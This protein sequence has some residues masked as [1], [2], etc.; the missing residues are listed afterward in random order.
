M[1]ERWFLGMIFFISIL[2]LAVAFNR[3]KK[4]WVFILNEL[5]PNNMRKNINEKI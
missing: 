3:P 4:P 5:N 2:G 1:L